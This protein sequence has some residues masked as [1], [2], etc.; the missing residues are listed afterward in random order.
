MARLL[1]LLVFLLLGSFTIAVN[2]EVKQEEEQEEEEQAV[3]AVQVKQEEEEQGVVAV[4]AVAFNEDLEDIESVIPVSEGEEEEECEEDVEDANNPECLTSDSGEEPPA[5]PTVPQPP[6]QGVDMIVIA[7]TLMGLTPELLWQRPIDTWEKTVNKTRRRLAAKYH[8]DKGGSSSQM[9]ELQKASEILLQAIRGWRA[10]TLSFGSCNIQC[11]CSRCL[12]FFSNRLMMCSQCLGVPRKGGHSAL[13]GLGPTSS[14]FM[15]YRKC[16]SERGRFYQLLAHGQSEA[17]AKECVA[18]EAAKRQQESKVL[19]R[20]EKAQKKQKVEHQRLE[21]DRLLAAELHQTEVETTRKFVD[22]NPDFVVPAELQPLMEGSSPSQQ[23]AN[24][25]S[26]G[27]ASGSAAS[28]LVVATAALAGS[29]TVDRTST[30]ASNGLPRP[31]G[32]MP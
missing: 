8:P 15:R 19:R 22:A 24:T 31:N 9:Q 6:L 32:F 10:P 23:A 29:G 21:L 28:P 12:H 3:V 26:S 30:T 5:A 4:E 27:G 20:C 7:E 16:K 2:N 25:I 17:M 13:C 1:Q 11:H 14:Y 18:A